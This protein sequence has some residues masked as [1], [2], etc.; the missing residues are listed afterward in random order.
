MNQKRLVSMKI[1]LEIAQKH[2][3]FLKR[4][5]KKAGVVG[6][7]S[8]GRVGKGITETPRPLHSGCYANVFKSLRK[9]EIFIGTSWV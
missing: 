8:W 9:A 7:I 4:G 3:T 2:F 6:E 1:Q 5:N